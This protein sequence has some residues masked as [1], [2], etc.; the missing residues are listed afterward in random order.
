MHMVLQQCAHVVLQ[1]CTHVVLQQ[2]THVVLQQCAHVANFLREA[3]VYARKQVCTLKCRVV[4][5]TK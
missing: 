2:C 5:S 4:L 1:Q 3:H